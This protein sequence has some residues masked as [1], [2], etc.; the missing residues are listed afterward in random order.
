MMKLQYFIKLKVLYKNC[1]INFNKYFD[2]ENRFLYFI[3]EYA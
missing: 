3:A 2:T 1:K